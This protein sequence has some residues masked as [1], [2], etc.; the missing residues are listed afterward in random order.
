MYYMYHLYGFMCRDEMDEER[1]TM[2]CQ[3]L[4]GVQEYF[5]SYW[6]FVQDQRANHSKTVSISLLFYCLLT[7]I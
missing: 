6:N 3:Q 7:I 2:I 5:I 1:Y 4:I